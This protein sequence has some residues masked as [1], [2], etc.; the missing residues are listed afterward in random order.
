MCFWI[1]GQCVAET[2]ADYRIDRETITNFADSAADSQVIQDQHLL[3]IYDEGILSYIL[4]AK[5]GE[6][7]IMSCK[8]QY[9]S[10]RI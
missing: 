5:G 7:R 6:I 2:F 10:Y 1:Y 9:V 4:L 8:W 3:K